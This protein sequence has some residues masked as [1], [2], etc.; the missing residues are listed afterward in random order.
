MSM[1]QHHVKSITAEDTQTRMAVVL[2]DAYRQFYGKPSDLALASRFIE[3]RLA[4]G[5]S[6][7][8]LA[9]TEKVQ[10][11]NAVGFMQLY[12]SFSSVSATH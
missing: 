12:P 7:I 8:F 6:V 3:Q 11:R 10:V 2:F 4:S 5:D 1:K 9:Y